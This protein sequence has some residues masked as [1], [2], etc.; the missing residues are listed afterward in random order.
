MLSRRQT[1]FSA[2]MRL[3]NSSPTSE[4]GGE[5]D[6][7]GEHSHALRSVLAVVAVSTTCPVAPT[8]SHRSDTRAERNARAGLSEQ[9]ASMWGPDK[10]R[11]WCRKRDSNPRPRHYELCGL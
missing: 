4:A 11:R 1:L 3:M 9:N 6:E 2:S 5:N 8:S 7:A 10:P